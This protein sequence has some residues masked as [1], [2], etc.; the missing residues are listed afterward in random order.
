MFA[1]RQALAERE[2]HVE[3][4]SKA[5]T[6]RHGVQHLGELPRGAPKRESE[7]LARDAPNIYVRQMYADRRATASAASTRNR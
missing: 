7:R 6:E 4:E 5:L 2:E 1:E 3:R